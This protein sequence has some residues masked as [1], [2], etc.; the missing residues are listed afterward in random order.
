MPG[1][2]GTGPVGLGSMTGGGFGFCADGI[3]AGVEDARY[4]GARR[5]RFGCGRAKNFHCRGNNVSEEK[6]IIE[7]ELKFLENRITGLRN[8][9]DKTEK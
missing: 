4:F 8:R 2:D 7:N 3:G 9:L 1:R 6:E 5:R